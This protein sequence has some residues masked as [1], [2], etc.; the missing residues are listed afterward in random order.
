MAFSYPEFYGRSEDDVE[1]FCEKMEVA[2]ISN[3]IHEAAQ[4]LRLL[5]LCLKG[6]ARTWSKAHEARLQAL[7]PPEHLT[8]DSLRTALAVRFAKI[9]EP[10]KVWQEVQGLKQQVDEPVEEYIRKFSKAW[11]RLCR[12]LQPAGAPPEMMK[13]D[14]FMAGLLDTLRWRVELKKPRTYDDLL[15]VA[16]NKE[17]KVKR[18]TQLGIGNE[19]GRGNMR[20]T[21]PIPGRVTVEAP[22]AVAIPMISQAIPVVGTTTAVDEGLKQEMRQV[23]DLMKNLSLNLLNNGGNI[24]GPAR[25]PNQPNGSGQG[26]NR[27]WRQMPTCYNCG[28]LGHISPQCNKPRRMGGDMY[29]LP[30]QLPN[31]SNDYGIEIN[32]EAR[33]SRFTMEEKGKEKVVN[34]VSLEKIGAQK[35][36]LVM[37]VGKRTTDERE[38]R[39]GAGPSRKKEKHQEGEDVKAKRKRQARRKFQVSDFPLG[40]GQASY[41]L[42]EDITSRK[43]DVTF[44]QLVEMVPKLKRQWKKLVNPKER[45]PEKNSV[46]VLSVEEVSDICPIVDVWHKRKNLGQGYV[47]GGAQICVITQTCVERMGLTVT[48]VSGFRIRLANHQKVKC[49]GVVKSLEI[50]AYAVKALVDFHVMPAGLGAYPIILGRPW[51]RAV[52]AVQ[53]WK[54]GTICLSGKAGGKKLFDMHTKRAL[55]EGLE[56]EEESSEEDSSTASEVDSEYSTSDSDG[57]VDVALILVE[58]EIEERDV[59]ALPMEEENDQVGGYEMIEELMQPKMR[60]E[61]KREILMKMVSTDL[62][63]VEK[64]EFMQM[65]DC[66][67][68]LFITSYEEIRGF[69]GEELH[70]PLKEGVKPVR[71][72]LRRMGQEQMKALQEEV[73]KLLRAG[74]IRPVQTPEWVSPTV[75]TPKKDGRWRICIDFKPLNAA[76]KK[77][78]YPLPFIDQILDSVAGHE[79][80]SV[81]DGFSGY[82]QLKIA[83]ED[84]EKTSFITPWG[85]FCYKVLPYGLTNGPAQYQKR[86]NWALAPF[87]GDFVKAFI[88]DFCVYSSRAEHC[89][90]LKKVLGRYDEC[91]GQLNPKKCHLA[92]PRVKLLGHV[93]SENGIE[94][95][96]DKVK[97]IILLPSPKSTKQLAT[98]VQKVKYMARFIPLS[99]QLLYPLQQAAKHDPLEWSDQC[100]EVF[101]NVKEVLGLM[102][103]MQAPDWGQVFYVN[104]SVGE[105]AI[106]AMLLQKGKQSQYMRPVYCASRVKQVAEK[107]LSEVELVM[108]SVVFACRRFRHYLLPRPFVF[109][110]SYTFLP[111]LI[112]GVNMSNSVKRWVIELQE[113]EFSFLVEESTRATLADLLTYKESPLVIKE[114]EVKK[115]IESA[116]EVK[117]A[118]V[119]L[120]DGSYRRSHDAASGGMVLYDQHGKLVGK[121]G[122]KIDAHS[123][124]EAEYLA[125]EVGLNMCLKRGVR[126]LCI[127]GDALLIVKQV[128]GVWKSKNTLLREMCFRIRNLLKQFEA[129][130]IRHIDRAHNGKAHEAAQEMIGELFVMKATLPLYCGRE[131]LGEEEEFLLTG[132]I[133][134]GIEKAKKYGFL[135]RV[136]RYK[137]IGDVLY[138]LG[139][140]LVLRRV[141]WKEELYRVLEEN[142]EGACGGHFAFK[143]TLHKILQEGYVWPS[144]QKD[145]HHWCVSCKRCQ[146]FG[147]RILKPELRKTILAHDIFE[148]WGVDAVGPLPI[149]SRGKSYILTAVDYLSRW[150]EAAAVRQITAKDVAKFVYENICCQFGVPLELLSDQGPGFRADLMTFLCEKMRI[151]HKYTTP[152]YPQCNGLNERFNG[153]LVQILSKVTEHQ[154]RNWD[155]EIPSALWAYRTS[156]KTSTGFTPFH[157]VYGKE[158]LLPVEVE[159]PAVK[160][161]EKVLNPSSDAFKD[162]LLQLQEVQ[163]DRMKALD[164]YEQVQKKALARVNEKVKE[165][166]IKDGDLVL[167]YNSKLDKTFQKKFQVKWEGPFKV[168]NC[169]ANGT[170]QLADLD[171]TLH[172]SRVNGLRLKAY[173]ARLMIVEK[174][175]RHENEHESLKTAATLEETLDATS[176]YCATADHE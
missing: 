6:E 105:D 164:Y 170:Y 93:V 86:A 171:G 69:K 35:E 148:K 146:L 15:E 1:E 38:G 30:T 89:E 166:G 25:P 23:V 45:E 77:D 157:L 64:E 19:P 97:S 60:L 57:E 132:L 160:L 124:N 167:R 142:H 118:H 91:G 48:G 51:L 113:F 43:A 58:S 144:L 122:F 2:C 87:I 11:E 18:M 123:N 143:V 21:E 14:R 47:D 22:Q 112:N 134:K 117:N 135:R 32:G 55:E 16:K 12:A 70:I 83:V 109:L 62:S 107:S 29:P 20:Q 49:L 84:Q 75:A 56:D 121:Q 90:K 111:Q 39:S 137:L 13:K 158:A 130:S 85:C 61:E 149:T 80:Y 106:G 141:P 66:F 99:S 152:Y 153:E 68:G 101:Q 169:F 114:E 110:T 65:V 46:K 119:L 74:F 59:F 131:S 63:L 108:V 5:Q 8:W 3:H 98:F 100:E 7:E 116:S 104:P 72:K 120:F 140:D 156:V 103:A 27:A 36:P 24:R 28:E 96:P 155:L 154:G 174:D 162:R 79:R 52:G 95:D 71:Q 163:L 82:F 129:W 125:L 127:R 115:V 37:P 128:L 161:L 172:A 94:A 102:P 34:V 53:D 165:K 88:D 175:E 92:Q 44:G 17:W 136:A 40:D 145:V 150:A 138:M 10:D 67:P 76:T 139:A 147:K 54:R 151:R 33:P 9:E 126:R 50:E 41:S 168:A 133:P 4:M 73:D 26:N 176:L 31:R 173:H 159:L 42:K 78:P 81:C